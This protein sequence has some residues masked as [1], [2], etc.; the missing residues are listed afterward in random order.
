V[1]KP[2]DAAGGAGALRVDGQ[3]EAARRWPIVRSLSP[4]KT[5][6]IEG[7]VRQFVPPADILATFPDVK[8]VNQQLAPGSGRGCR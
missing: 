6:V 2:V 8:V 1:I 7:Q 5:A 4:S 3:D